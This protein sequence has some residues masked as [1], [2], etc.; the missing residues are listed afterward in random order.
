MQKVS[1][2][3]RDVFLLFFVRLIVILEK[4]I[5]GAIDLVNPSEHT[6]VNTLCRVPVLWDRR[7]VLLVD[8]P[9]FTAVVWL[10]RRDNAGRRSLS[11]RRTQTEHPVASTDDAI[12]D[13]RDTSLNNA[14]RDTVDDVSDFARQDAGHQ[15]SEL[16]TQQD[17]KRADGAQAGLQ[18]D[19]CCH[20]VAHVFTTRSDAHPRLDLVELAADLRPQPPDHRR[21]AVIF[22]RHPHLL[23]EGEEELRR[24]D[25]DHNTRGE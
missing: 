11:M 5:S 10:L 4:T 12:G 23:D 8:S 25:Q 16:L 2:Y 3:E 22:P 13:Y 20:V 21:V 19:E 6:L 1:H 9:L 7:P 17:L 18:Q 15:P 14:R 24:C